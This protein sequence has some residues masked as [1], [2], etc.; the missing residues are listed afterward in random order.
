MATEKINGIGEVISK[1]I[2][3]ELTIGAP[4]Y[5]NDILRIGD[6]KTV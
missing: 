5:V 4:V 6:W 1:Y 2:T 3:P